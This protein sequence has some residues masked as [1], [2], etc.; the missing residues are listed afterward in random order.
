M[1]NSYRLFVESEIEQSLIQHLTLE[2]KNPVSL[3][4]RVFGET[5]FL[6]N[7]SKELAKSQSR[8]YHIICSRSI[9]KSLTRG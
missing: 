1:R 2:Y 8:C 9:V 7:L 5:G 4:N 6:E 3:R